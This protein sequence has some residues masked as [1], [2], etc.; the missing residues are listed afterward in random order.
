[1]NDSRFDKSPAEKSSFDDE[2]CDI[3]KV[4]RNLDFDGST[5]TPDQEEKPSRE[6]ISPQ[7]YQEI[8]TEH[9]EE[10]FSCS[11]TF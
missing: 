3:E 1:L 6:T 2:K 9:L 8:E 4:K 11:G 7:D 5:E 10:S